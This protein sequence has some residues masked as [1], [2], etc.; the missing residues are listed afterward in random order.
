[1]SRKRQVAKFDALP[2]SS[3]PVITLMHDY[4]AGHRI[5]LHFHDRDQLVFATSGVMTVTTDKGAWVVPFHRAVW[6]P[7]GIPHSI[8][9][10]GSVT[11]RTLYFKSRVV[12]S[13][14]RQCCVVNVP[15]LLRELILETCACGSLQRRIPWQLHLLEV[16]LGRLEVLEVAPLQLP[17][18]IDTR[19]LRVAHLLL[20]CPADRSPLATLSR[21][22][23][24]SR[25][26]IERLFVASTGMTFGRWRQQLRLMHAMRLLG[27][28]AK[29]THAALEAGYSNSSAFIFAFRKALGTTPARYF[30]NAG[31]VPA[32]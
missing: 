9:M 4:P 19:A 18:P 5:P 29:V 23:G 13:L 12:R 15:A 8:S 26:T 7:Q 6:I 3:A 21:D 2:R 10:S 27:G 28:G 31:R 16:I 11:M 20:A 32:S 24:A 25:R 30:Q 22:S 14:G 1:M 17:L